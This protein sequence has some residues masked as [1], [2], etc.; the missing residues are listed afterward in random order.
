[1]THDDQ[2]PAGPSSSSGE[3][4]SFN[5]SWQPRPETAAAAAAVVVEFQL[6][7][8]E[9]VPGLRRQL[10]RSGRLRLVF[11]VG[12][13][14]ILV[15]AL[16]AGAQDASVGGFFVFVG[17]FYI[18]L[19]S[20]AAILGPRRAWRRNP[21][22]RGPQYIAFSAD[23]IYARSTVAESRQQWRVYAAMIETERCYMLRLATRKAYVFVPKRAF[24]SPTDE[25]VFRHLVSLHMRVDASA[26]ARA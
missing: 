21:T 24:K 8:D 16:L 2:Q 15:G 4:P 23:G 18:A 25:A 22:L 3:A 14:L 11:A 1:V 17:V 5:T 26:K 12:V 6:T 13:F 7:E 20:A 9:V 10:I 19:I